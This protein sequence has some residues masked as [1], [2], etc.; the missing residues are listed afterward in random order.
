M[1]LFQKLFFIPLSGF[2]TPFLAFLTIHYYSK[3][4]TELQLAIEIP[5]KSDA[6]FTNYV[7]IR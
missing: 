6:F 1:I 7:L 5:Y 4:L 2:G 3:Q